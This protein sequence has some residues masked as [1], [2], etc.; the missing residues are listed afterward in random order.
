MKRNK[1]HRGTAPV[2]RDPDVLWSG[3]H[4]VHGKDC[5]DIDCRFFQIV[6]NDSHT[7]EDR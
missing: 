4:Y 3:S 2:R 1:T 6:Y 5:A 7:G